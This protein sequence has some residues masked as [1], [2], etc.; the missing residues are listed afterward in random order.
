MKKNATKRLLAVLM[1]GV[2]AF[3]LMACGGKDQDNADPNA[4]VALTEEEYQEA[5]NELGA[6]MNEIQKGVADAQSDPE[7]AK[8]I[9]ADVKTTLTDFMALT[10]PESYAAGH[11]KIKSG[12]ATL[13]EALDIA[14]EMVNMDP[15]AE[16]DMEKLTEML[17]QMQEKLTTGTTE[18]MEGA[19]LLEEADKK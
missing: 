1:A 19:K 15:T 6:K 7:A 5:A 18:L 16:P 9:L 4:P 13:I 10:P 2:M 14:D 12:C 3:S 8:K 17:T 11:E